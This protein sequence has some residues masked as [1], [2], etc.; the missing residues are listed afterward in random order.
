[1]RTP[2]ASVLAATALVVALAAGVAADA[3]L[4]RPDVGGPDRVSARAP[5][6]GA[7]YCTV[8]DTAE[9]NRLELLG[10]VPPIGVTSAALRIDT[11]GD[12]D[13]SRLGEVEIFRGDLYHTRPI[14][15]EAGDRGVSAR[16]WR[17]A[18]AVF[19]TWHTGRAGE[20]A[21]IV[22]GPCQSDPS[23]LWHLPGVSTAGGSQARLVLGN[24][25][26]TDAAVAV[27]LVTPEGRREPERLKNVGIPGHTIRVI[28]LNEHA[29][30]EPDLGAVVTVRAGRVVAEAWESSAAAVGDVDGVTLA[31]LTPDSSERWTVPWF[32]GPGAQTWVRV[33]NVTDDEALVNVTVHTGEGGS[34]P[35]GLEEIT[36]PA[37]TVQ[38]VELDAVLPDGVESGAVT[39]TSLNDVPVVASVASRLRGGSVERSGIT[40]QLGRPAP[41]RLWLIGTAAGEGRREI[42]H[43]VNPSSEAADVDVSV[44]RPAGD[45]H[46]PEEW[47]DL[48]VPAGTTIDV[49][50]TEVT[51]GL[52][53]HAVLVEAREGVVVAG[54]HSFAS[55]GR[56][57]LVASSGVDGTRWEGGKRV[58]VVDHAP[59][60]TRRVGT[61]QGPEAT[62]QPTLPTGD[63]AFSPTPTATD[64]ESP[65]SG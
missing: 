13:S 42:V 26:P 12:G 52:E 32:Q 45:I 46:A 51:G 35:E 18:T 21:G 40:V 58:P 6:S 50:V 7:W 22:E 41:A 64:V 15:G 20:P 30:E 62:P 28:D 36:V 65:G 48:A 55:D 34:P 53:E 5:T 8:G 56:L 60:L 23:G 59:G 54:L 24:P 25:F 3:L 10:A 44:L 27:E 17:T 33:A 16:W 31:A 47:R 61:A 19:R 63:P 14:P 2:T 1:M 43:V 38:R 9:G 4:P 57:N 11:F 29:P 39:V 49:D 37:G